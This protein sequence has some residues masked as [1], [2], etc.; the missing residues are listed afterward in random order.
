MKWPASQFLKS[1]SECESVA[2][3]AWSAASCAVSLVLRSVEL[4]TLSISMVI[5]RGSAHSRHFRSK[6]SIA[7][8]RQLKKRM[9]IG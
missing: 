8:G 6:R 2:S 4:A 7:L 1:T 9:V 3:G 5:L